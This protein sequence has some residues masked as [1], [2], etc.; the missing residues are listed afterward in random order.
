MRFAAS[1]CTRPNISSGLAAQ[2]HLRYRFWRLKRGL[3]LSL[4]RMMMNDEHGPLSVSGFWVGGWGLGGSHEVGNL[5]LFGRY[6]RI[7]AVLSIIIS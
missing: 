3:S 4:G 2:G 7:S 1:G 5:G 6:H